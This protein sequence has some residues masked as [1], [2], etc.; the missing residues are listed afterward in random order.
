MRY[1]AWFALPFCAAA[2]LS[3]KLPVWQFVWPLAGLCAFALVPVLL[4]RG[5]HTR[6]LALL[7]VGACLGFLWFGGYTAVVAQPAQDCDGLESGFT[8]VVNCYPEETPYGVSVSLRMESGSAQGMV[9]QTYLDRYYTALKPGDRIT[10]TACFSASVRNGEADGSRST[11]RGIFLVASAE[12]YSCYSSPRVPVRYLPAKLGH[13]LKATVN[14]LFSGEEAALLQG[15]LTG[16]KSGLSDALYTGFRRSGMAHLLAVSGLHVGFLSGI[17]YLLPG[18]KRRRALIAIPVM[19]CFALMTGG[20]PS[21]WRAVVMASLL[22]LAPLCGRESDAPT[23]LA[24]ALLLLLLQN[25]YAAESVGLQLSFAAVVGLV[26]FQSR[27]YHW[28]MRPL[29]GWNRSDSLRRRVAQRVAGVL[30]AGISTACA[31]NVFTLPLAAYYFKTVSLLGPLSNLLCIW[32]ASL[33]FALGMCACVLFRLCPPLGEL[34][35]LPERWLLDYLI[36]LAEGLGRGN[37]AALRLD[38]LYLRVWLLALMA[39]VALVIALKPLRRRPILPMASAAALLALAL[40]FRMVSLTAPPLCVSVLD[41][42]QGACTVFSSGGTFAAVDC[43]GYDAGNRLADYVQ[44]GG[45]DRLSLLVLT[46]FDSDHVNGVELSLI[47]I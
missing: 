46:H 22:L 10:G 5:R 7:S 12:V 14:T 1:L 34:L 15:L 24:F 19:V 21:V 2:F 11:A 42:G 4:A 38:N 29:A 40:T 39:L 44:S 26:S 25:P 43:G 45:A 35:A 20:Q 37:F 36:R 32:A 23:S 27:M 17:L 28:M 47:H 9:V 18:Q 3:C 8:A 31:A 41:V 16:D 6:R 33:A 30:A 13:E